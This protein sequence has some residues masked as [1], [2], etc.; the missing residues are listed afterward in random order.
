MTFVDVTA[1]WTDHTT[2]GQAAYAA[3]MNAAL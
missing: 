2:K 3:L 1:A